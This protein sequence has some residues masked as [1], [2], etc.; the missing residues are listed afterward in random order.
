MAKKSKKNILIV[1]PEPPCPL[2]HSG[3]IWLWS[4][5]SL[6]KDRYDFSLVSFSPSGLDPLVAAAQRL[7]LQTVFKEV[8]WVPRRHL[9]GRD[10]WLNYHER[11]VGDS[12]DF[13][14][15][16]EAIQ[17]L[18]KPGEID[19]V[20]LDHVQMLPCLR[21][22]RSVPVLLAEHD[23]GNL[24]LTSGPIPANQREP[25]GKRISQALSQY[26]Y[27]WAS[28]RRLRGMAFLGRADFLWFRRH[29]RLCPFSRK[30]PLAVVP[31]GVDIDGFPFREA[32]P[33]DRF[34][35]IVFTGNYEHLPNVEGVL[36]FLKDIWPKVLARQPNARFWIVGANPPPVIRCFQSPNVR[37]TDRV[38]DVR[39]F[40]RSAH[41]F[42]APIRSGYGMKG[43]ILEAMAIGVPVVTTP[44]VLSAWGRDAESV[45]CRGSTANRFAEHV[46]TLLADPA[47]RREMAQRAR[48]WVE[49]TSSWARSA[50]SLDRLY[51]DCLKNY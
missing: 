34:M 11:R 13:L 25:W 37:V 24:R 33:K 17:G 26:L 35:N 51:S 5:A 39:P 21:Y 32:E 14:S 40:L 29:R 7:K 27:Y 15:L 38:E 23:I 8:R 19:L 42:V 45:V 43:K 3:L 46:I 9:S 28:V 2:I 41:V 4:L 30:S 36:Y 18:L 16:G 48:R 20:H 50:E 44:R 6:L 31:M 49:R 12:E 1:T 22:V 10:L 47:D